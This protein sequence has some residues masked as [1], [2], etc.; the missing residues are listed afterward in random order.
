MMA[1][2]IRIEV[3]SKGSRKSRNSRCPDGLGIAEDVAAI[4]DLRSANGDAIKT[5]EMR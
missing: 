1:I 4:H 3:T 2:R 5:G